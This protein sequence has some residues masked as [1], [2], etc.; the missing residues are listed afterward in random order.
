MEEELRQLKEDVHDSN[1][2][3]KS[4]QDSVN[5]YQLE[6]SESKD[7]LLSMEEVK[8]TTALQCSAT[9]DSL[10]TS[11][12]HLSDL[13]D[14]V[15]RL[16]YM[17]EEEK[18]KRRLAEERYIQQQEEYDVALRKRQKELETISWSKVELEKGMANR[19]HEVEQLR[20]QLA[21][22]S[23]KVTELQIE[24]SKVRSEFSGEINNLKLSYESQMLASLTDI[25]RLSAQR[26]DD[27]AQLQLQYD[28]MEAEKRDM[29]EELRRLRLSI[30]QAEEQRNRADEK[31][32]D[33]HMIVTEEGRMRREL[34]SQVELL[35][36]QRQEDSSQHREELSEVMKSLEEKSEQLAYITH[37]LE[38]ETRRRK[39][40]EEGNGVLEEALA[41]LQVKLTNS[42]AAVTQLAECEEELQK[43]RME[44]ER[45]SR[46]RSRVEQNTSRLQVRLKD[47]QAVRDELEGRLENMR[48]ANQEEASRRREIEAEL[49]KTTM[50]MTEHTS[51]IIALRQSQEQAGVTEKRAEEE[52]LRV[53]EELEISLTQNKTL[54]KQM[55]ELSAELKALEQQLL[56]EQARVQEANQQNKV[57]S[58]TLEEK[59]KEVNEKSEESAVELQRLKEMIE[60]QTQERL[61][62]EEE[63]KAARHDKDEVVRSKKRSDDELSSQVTALELQL[64]AS[65]R[66]N[67][68][69]R[70]LVSELSSEREKL[71]LEVE[72]IQKLTIEVHGSLELSWAAVVLV[73]DNS[74]AVAKPSLACWSSFRSLAVAAN[75]ATVI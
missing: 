11:Q 14:Q 12:S 42:S 26:E 68:D 3:N 53:Q 56:Q 46:E 61:R 38:E 39:T 19:E 65:Q 32:N 5:R 41:Q 34:E 62:L 64:Q 52:W 51:T 37:S 10:D 67:V 36:I 63:L 1:S 23:T 73:W 22:E 2:K 71:R 47:I 18:R 17:L 4:L 40:I 13:Q 57:L 20:R 70:N 30:D 8:R 33:Q 49:E 66:N 16:N 21:E 54:T 74:V 7:Q 72:N 24:T 75:L 50:T 45:E 59:S 43:V 27:A 25:Q 15:T 48:E 44:L 6:L 28:R 31:A 9:K 60:T 35:I 58:T 69:H 55:E 29:E